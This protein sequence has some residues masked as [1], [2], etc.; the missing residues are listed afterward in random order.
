MQITRNI[1]DCDYDLTV[2]AFTHM[3]IELKG[4]DR[5]DIIESLMMCNITCAIKLLRT[6]AIVQI[7]LQN[8]TE[9][10]FDSIKNI[11]LKQSLKDIVLK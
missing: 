6:I 1:I 7:P 11:L 5:N 8:L 9:V 2:I 4:S 3:Y 10:E